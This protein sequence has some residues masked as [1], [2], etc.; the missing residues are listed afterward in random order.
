[1]YIDDKHAHLH[2]L[3]EVLLEANLPLILNTNVQ[4]VYVPDCIDQ[5]VLI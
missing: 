2:H 5:F 1:M 4:H 3:H